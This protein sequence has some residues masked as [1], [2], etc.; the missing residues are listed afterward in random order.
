MPGITPG[1]IKANYKDMECK[2]RFL[3]VYYNIIF[4]SDYF[5]NGK[6]FDSE[7]ID[8]LKELQQDCELFGLA[9]LSKQFTKLLE[10]N[11]IFDIYAK[12]WAKRKL[13]KLNYKRY[14]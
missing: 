10:Q 8:Y 13:T 14:V 9:E 6:I 5:P 11:G 4:K 12:F 2:L 7:I 1:S 3:Y